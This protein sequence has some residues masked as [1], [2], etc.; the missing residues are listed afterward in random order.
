MS[1][2][3]GNRLEFLDSLRGL[4]ALMVACAHF[5]ERT[6]LHNSFLFKHVNFGQVGV[7]CFFV[8][9]GMVIPYSLKEGKRAISGFII[10]RFL[11]Y[12]PLTGFQ[13]FWRPLLFCL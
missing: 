1:I 8:L 9:S 5:I 6:P 3:N 13:Y 4:A 10:S 2:R 7:V 12:I 11:D